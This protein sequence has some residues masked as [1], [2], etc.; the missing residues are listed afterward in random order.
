MTVLG[1]ATTGN[2]NGLA[3]AGELSAGSTRRKWGEVVP[4]LGG[5]CPVASGNLSDGPPATTRDAVI[6]PYAVPGAVGVGGRAAAPAM[7]AACG[8]QAA[9]GGGVAAAGAV[10]HCG[11]IG[12]VVVAAGGSGGG[13]RRP[14]GDGGR[15]AC[16]VGRRAAAVEGG[17]GVE[18]QGPP[19]PASTP[20]LARVAVV[21][22]TTA[23]ADGVG[24]SLAAATGGVT[25]FGCGAA[26]AA[27]MSALAAT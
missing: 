10:P 21:T 23:D 19:C 25:A 15:R 2:D 9:V 17:V 20:A 3:A 4:T 14:R 11:A 13:R 24:V 18:T 1:A 8:G 12:A 5:F 27:D 22:T 16:G 26:G 6:I 7:A